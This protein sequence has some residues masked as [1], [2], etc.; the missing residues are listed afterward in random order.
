[1]AGVFNNDDISNLI[2]PVFTVNT[3][4]PVT[5]EVELIRENLTTDQYE[6]VD[7]EMAGT[8]T[9]TLTDNLLVSEL[10]G[11]LINQ[12]ITYYALQIDLANNPS[13]PMVP[14][15]SNITSDPTNLTVLLDNVPPP[16]PNAPALDPSTNSGTN[17]GLNIT[18]NLHPLFDVT[19]LLTAGAVAPYNLELFRSIGGSTP[20]L[21]GTAV[22]ARPRSRTPPGFLPMGSISIRW[23]RSMSPATSAR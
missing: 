13:T 4:E 11:A 7:T 9:V 22:P 8:G 23:S 1:M 5:T 20:I 15:L 14:P 2:P 21:V 12:S 3:T 10:N 6:V 17:K 19:G 18:N 16:A